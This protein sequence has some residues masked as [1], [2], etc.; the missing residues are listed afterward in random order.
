MSL[1]EQLVNELTLDDLEGEQKALAECL[2]L[3][4]Y[5]RLL[6]MYAGSTFTV[7][8]PDK[9]TIPLRNKRIRSEF[10]GYNWGELARKYNLH[11]KTIRN[12]VSGEISRI[13]AE[14][15]DGQASLF[16]DDD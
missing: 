1:T 3:E 16:D 11:E 5:K 8:M 2:G 4:A 12:I 6:L 13:R 10:N 7:R 15:M 9:V 14:P